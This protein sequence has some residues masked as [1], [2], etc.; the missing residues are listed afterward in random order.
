M[1]RRFKTIFYDKQYYKSKKWTLGIISIAIQN[2]GSF[3]L[4]ELS[5]S[6]STILNFFVVINTV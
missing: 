4:L 1:L 5:A 2:F 6:Q 3:F